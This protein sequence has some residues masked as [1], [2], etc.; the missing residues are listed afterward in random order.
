MISCTEFIPLYNE[1]F[2]YIDNKA[3]HDAVVRYWEVIAD[4]Y[5]E[6]TLGTLV[7]EKGLAG[8]Y[9]YWARALNEEAADFIMKYDEKKEVLSIE[10]RWCPSRGLLNSLKHIE[11][12]YDYC[13]HCSVLYDHVLRKRGIEQQVDMSH[14]DEAA[15]SEI[16][17]YA[18]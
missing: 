3:G 15:C 1:L 11:P 16:R 2:K 13:G 12:Y 10:T 6:K 14:I 18:K 17:Y 9:E 7:D 5:V 8:A 4:R